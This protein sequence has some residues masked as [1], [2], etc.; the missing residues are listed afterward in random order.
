[1]EIGFVYIDLAKPGYVCADC[2]MAFP[3]QEKPKAS[4]DL[5]IIIERDLRPWKQA[6]GHVWL[7]NCGETPCA[8]VEELGCHQLVSNLCRSTGDIVQTVVTHGND[9]LGAP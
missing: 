5:D 1:M 4:L 6:H 2:F 3:A 7:S 8:A 9:L